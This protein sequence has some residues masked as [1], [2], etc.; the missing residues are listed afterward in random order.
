MRLFVLLDALLDVLLLLPHLHLLAVIFDHV[1]HAIHHG[2]DPLA[3]G[4]NHLLTVLLFLQS[5]AHIL[6][7]LI[8]VGLFN[9]K[10]LGI[11]F[12]LLVHV[13]LNHSHCSLA[14]SDFFAVL[15]ALLFL[16]VSI[17]LSDAV[18]LFHLAVR[19][20]INLLLFRLFHHD[21][22]HLLLLDDFSL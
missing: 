15:G 22:A 14:L 18:L 4:S 3:T 13:F 12:L 5:H 1:D 19:L 20:I 11:A 10:Q 9:C 17:E 6:L 21:V 2:L 7:Y 16:K 8:G